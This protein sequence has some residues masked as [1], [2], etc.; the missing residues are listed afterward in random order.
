MGNIEKFDAMA[1]QYD[2]PERARIAKI[3][4]GAI[5]KRVASGAD[6]CA[7]DYGCGTG[8]VGICLADIFD[9]LVLIDASPNMIEQVNAKIAGIPNAEALCRDF[10]REPPDVRADYIFLTQVLLHVKDIEPFLA[11]L[12]AAL[13]PGGRLL[14]VDFNKNEA[15]ASE[16]VHNGFD[17]SELAEVLKRIGFLSADSETFYRGERIFM[18]QDASLFILDAR[19]A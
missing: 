12:F 6:K 16:L 15:V 11:S 5:R 14:I 3:I 8:L 19:K 2:T 4:A 17:Q 7:V 9:S 18:N 13:N 10:S 1:T